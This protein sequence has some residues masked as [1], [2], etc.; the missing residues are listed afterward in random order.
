MPI[1][2]T[3]LISYCRYRIHT[4]PLP[5]CRWPLHP[6][7]LSLRA[8]NIRNFWGL[9]LAQAIRVT[10]IS[11]FYLM[12]LTETKVADQDDCLNSMVYDV[13]C[14]KVITEEV[15]GVQGG[16]VLVVRD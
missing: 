14:S 16:L 6:R 10:Q 2:F 15:G 9:G 13:V 1:F 11:S 7:I 5:P 12:I 8:F 4:E 3:W